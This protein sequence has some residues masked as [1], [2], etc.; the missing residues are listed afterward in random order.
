MRLNWFLPFRRK[1]KRDGE[2]GPGPI[3]RL[4]ERIVPTWLCSPVH[5]AVQALC[6]IAFAWLFLYVCWP[7]TARPAR[8]WSGWLPAE[9]DAET[10]KVTLVSEHAQPQAIGPDMVLYVV[11][12]SGAAGG[13]AVAFRVTGVGDKELTME[14]ASPPPSF[15]GR[16]G[17][18]DRL[19]ESFGPWSL[20][21]TD[22]GQ[23]PSHYA[24]ELR[25]RQSLGTGQ[26]LAAEAFL[27]IDPLVSISTALAARS[28]FWALSFADTMLWWSLGC[29][30]AVLLICLVI[31]R[32]F[33]GYVCPMGTL[34]DLFDWAVGRW[35]GR[36]RVGSDGWWVHVKYYL[37][38]ATLI[39]SLCGVLLSGFVSAIPILTRGTAFLLT[40][41]QLGLERGWHQVPPL[42]PGHVLS[43][44]LFLA[45]LGLGVLRPRFWCKYVCPTGA[46]FSVANHLRLTQRKVE[47][48]CVG[49]NCC[50]E[51]CP[52]DAIKPDFTTRVTDCTFCQTCGGACPVHAIKF[53]SRWHKADLRAAGDPPTGESAIGRR[54]FLAAT[55]GG[56]TGCLGGAGA[57]AIVG[58]TGARLE[59]AAA[60]RP[61]RPPGSVSEEAFLQMCIRCGQCFQA[62]P[63]SVLQP[64]GFQ[65]GLEGLWTPQVVADWSGC[66][67]SCSNCGQVCPTGAIRALPLEE[68]RV[69]RMGLAV[70]DKKTCLPYAKRE[71]CQLCVDECVAAGYDA[72]EFM[73]V[74]TEMDDLGRPIEGTG[75]LAPVVLPGRCVG[76]GL[77]Q[78]RCRAVNAA[79]KGLLKETAIRVEAGEGREDRV[80]SSS[81]RELRRRE[82]E[83][84][85]QEQR[86]LLNSSGGKGNYLPDF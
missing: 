33:C 74:G 25:A 41:L 18:I 26:S 5:R 13:D 86:K 61:V 81:Y 59:A 51:I 56:A 84:R 78:T 1:S 31:P 60:F 85:Q 69:A 3:R 63:N 54:G 40:P 21:E 62:C 20:H 73:R 23:W 28:Q 70:V 8:I 64:L 58:A 10:G 71:A 7:Y 19:A 27:M 47:S 39:G 24:D 16:G 77:C 9:V 46:V 11:D 75:F 76:C 80:M 44:V 42:G 82:E 4:L 37:L 38:L 35:A 29:A 43:I 66:E 48:S 22:P 52:F 17:R 15:A 72:I 30:A 50:V 14:P 32:G 65:Q 55:I 53:V 34:I 68:K 57:A 83:K 6:F 12:P 79:Q 2:G 36:L 49:C 45:V 67:P